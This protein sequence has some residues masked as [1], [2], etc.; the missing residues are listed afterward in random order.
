[1][2]IDTTRRLASEGYGQA[3]IGMSELLQVATLEAPWHSYDLTV[4]PQPKLT[5]VLSMA[6]TAL[7]PIHC[8]MQLDERAL[9]SQH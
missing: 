5:Y 1:M 2:A 6:F 4:V 8:A 7:I 3:I 9:T